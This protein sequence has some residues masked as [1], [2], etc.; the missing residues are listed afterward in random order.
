MAL[1]ADSSDSHLSVQLQV[2][3]KLSFCFTISSA[4]LAERDFTYTLATILGFGKFGVLVQG[5]LIQGY[6]ENI[7]KPKKQVLCSSFM[8]GSVLDATGIS[9]EEQT[10]E[11]ENP[12]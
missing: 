6:A 3:S 1:L 9:S 10:L 2:F 11:H 7:P 5:L 4:S 8:Y 12:L